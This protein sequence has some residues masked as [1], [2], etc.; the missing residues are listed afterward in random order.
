MALRLSISGPSSSGKSAVIAALQDYFESEGKRVVIRPSLSRLHSG[1]ATSLETRMSAKHQLF[2]L[3][4][5][6][7]A[8]EAA[9]RE[10]ADVYIFDRTIHDGYVYNLEY[11]TLS[12]EELSKYFHDV[13]AA[14]TNYDISFFLNAVVWSEDSVRLDYDKNFAESFKKLFFDH[15]PKENSSLVEVPPVLGIENLLSFI[16]SAIDCF[17]LKNSHEVIVNAKS[18][19]QMR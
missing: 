18:D 4:E 11:A 1:E 13:K 16:L 17:N 7:K 5:A 19:K 10:K 9:L 6:I 8:D 3:S 14:L 15:W 2:L 12:S